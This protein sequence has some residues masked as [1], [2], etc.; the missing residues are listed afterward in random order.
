MTTNATLDGFPLDASSPIGWTFLPGTEPHRRLL[1]CAASV[2]EAIFSQATPGES[3]LTFDVPGHGL[4][5][6]ERLTVIGIGPTTDPSL[7][8]IEVADRRWLLRDRHVYGRFNVRRRTGE[9]RRVGA[10]LP[11]AVQPINDDVAFAPWSINGSVRWE[12]GDLIARVL[13]RLLPAGE[14]LIRPLSLRSFPVEDLVL[15]GQAPGELRRLAGYFGGLIDYFV[16]AD[17]TFVV[18]D[19]ADE[20]EQQIVG[21]AG[22]GRGTRVRGSV[23]SGPPSVVGPQLWRWV[24]RSIERPEEFRVLVSRLIELRL[25]GQDEIDGGADRGERG[26]LPLDLEMVLEVTDLELDI[27]AMDGKPARKV[28]KGA[29]VTFRE[30]LAAWNVAG[31]PTPPP[32]ARRQLTL[33]DIRNKAM[34]PDSLYGTFAPPHLDEEGIYSARIGSILRNFRQTYRITRRWRDRMGEI[35]AT[36]AELKDSENGTWAPSE[37]FADYSNIL[38]RRGQEAFT[39]SATNGAIV[40]NRYAAGEGVS[41]KT[42]SVTS[43]RPASAVVA[44]VDQD[45]GII[46]LNYALE[47]RIGERGVFYS[48]TQPAT[49]ASA[50]PAGPVF[51]QGIGL[52]K[53]TARHEVSVVLSTTAVAPNDTRALHQVVVTPAEVEQFLGMTFGACRGPRAELRVPPSNRRA[54]ARFA[55]DDARAAEIRLAFR[56]VDQDQGDP[57]TAFGDPLNPD[58]LHA[59]AL[60]ACAR[61]LIQRRD[62]IEGGLT[63]GWWPGIR[64]TGNAGPVTY[65]VDPDGSATTGIAFRRLELA[66]DFFSYLPDHVRQVVL[67]EV[68]P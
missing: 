17:G 34:V 52:T 7:A 53:L 59:L 63:T 16:D 55:W 48:A 61:H 9:R 67:G 2:A 4:E 58:E 62:Q 49:I 13:G 5:R 14:F 20:S 66:E 68:I 27:P 41:I 64:P 51:Q 42:S 22:G 35:F 60:A 37:A 24:D 47:Q 10:N 19:R 29:W 12:A 38:T 54:M 21:L 11:L 1:T 44:V 31:W 28:L 30:A 56:F 15:D 23:S 65:T 8:T 18:Y 50:N 25:D 36:R 6:I 3:V 57:S 26:D 40:V 45:Q 32:M 33:V 39:G 46:R 43:M